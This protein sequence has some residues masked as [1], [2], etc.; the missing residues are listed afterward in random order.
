MV[1]IYIHIVALE[2]SMLHAKIFEGV[3][4]YMAMS[5]ILSCYLDYLKIQWFAFYI[6]VSYNIWPSRFKEE[7]V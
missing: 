2:S 6:N 5:V 1:M 7:D 3:L 4:P